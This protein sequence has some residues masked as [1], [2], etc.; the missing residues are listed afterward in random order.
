MKK[1]AIAVALGGLFMMASAQ[2]APQ[3]NTWYAGG[4]LGWSNYQV[5]KKDVSNAFTSYDIT[6]HDSVG[7]GLYA[8]YQF[9]QY[10]GLEGGYDYLGNLKYSATPS[11]DD[12]FRT[13]GVSLAAKLGY[14]IAQGVDLYGKAGGFGYFSKGEGKSDN[15]LS[16]LLA[17][18]TELAPI[19]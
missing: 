8:G 3:D 19:S 9:N 10:L 17:V 1:T 14:E 7:G 12:T 11:S 5:G 18:G 6:R 16:P 4:K 2:A 13:Q 15:G